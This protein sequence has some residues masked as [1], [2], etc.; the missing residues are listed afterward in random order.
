MTQYQE[1]MCEKDVIWAG[2]LAHLRDFIKQAYLAKDM[3]DTKTF[4]QVRNE[5]G[6]RKAQKDFEEYCKQEFIHYAKLDFSFAEIKRALKLEGFKHFKYKLKSDKSIKEILGPCRYF[7]LFELTSKQYEKT[8]LLDKGLTCDEISKLF[9][10]KIK[11]VWS[12]ERRLRRKFGLPVR[13]YN[14]KINNFTKV[15]EER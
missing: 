8:R 3:L 4:K 1:T 11:T 15:H 14:K 9:G 7:D 5:V 6:K 13:K 10:I 12:V 2:A